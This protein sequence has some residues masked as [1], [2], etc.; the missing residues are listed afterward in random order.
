MF[1]DLVDH[2]RMS[3]SNVWHHL[4]RIAEADIELT[5]LSAFLHTVCHEVIIQLALD[6]MTRACGEGGVLI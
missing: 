3:S 5:T 2:L 1:S 6:D 4:G